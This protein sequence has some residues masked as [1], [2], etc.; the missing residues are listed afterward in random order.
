MAGEYEVPTFLAD[1][2]PLSSVFL[3][4]QRLDSND[5]YKGFA[6]QAYMETYTCLTRGDSEVFRIVSPIFKQNMYSGVRVELRPHLSPV[7]L[8]HESI[9]DN[10]ETFPLLREA[11]VI[12][13]TLKE[14][15]ECLFI[16]AW[17]WVQS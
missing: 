9:Y 17:W 7:D 15:G 1:I 11:Q 8:F 16:P 10:F 6:K 3:S 2:I 5:I 13:V 4:Y 14:P 12:E